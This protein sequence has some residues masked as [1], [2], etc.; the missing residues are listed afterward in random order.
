MKVLVWRELR[1]LKIILKI[2][3][4]LLIITLKKVCRVTINIAWNI[5]LI[6]LTIINS[7]IND[8][9][10]DMPC[11]PNN[12]DTSQFNI[13]MT[14]TTSNPLRKR[15]HSSSIPVFF[16]FFFFFFFFSNTNPNSRYKDN[17]Y[18]T[19]KMIAS[20]LMDTP[21]NYTEVINCPNKFNWIN[22][23]NNE[24]NNLYNNKIMIFVKH[25]PKK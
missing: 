25:I 3:K 20:V 9:D 7:I 10:S 8:E 2:L 14:D 5:L 18:K 15:P 21:N 4:I 22:A 23:I 17:H 6:H 24:L 1:L 19:D 12:N 16:F 11:S 13:K